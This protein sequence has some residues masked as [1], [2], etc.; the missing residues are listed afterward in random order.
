MVKRRKTHRQRDEVKL[1]A[2]TTNSKHDSGSE[3]FG[4]V[5][6]A[7]SYDSGWSG[8]SIICTFGQTLSLGINTVEL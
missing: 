8:E 5:S 4:E 1:C 6:F 2:G 7:G 3:Q